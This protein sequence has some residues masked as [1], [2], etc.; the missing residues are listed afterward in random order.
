M[1]FALH[2]WS[3]NCKGDAIMNRNISKI[4]ALAAVFNFVAATFFIADGKWIQGVLFFAAAVCFSSC[5]A[6]RRKKEADEEAS[7]RAED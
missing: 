6:I 1:A 3:S 4:S 5:A 7:G 2:R